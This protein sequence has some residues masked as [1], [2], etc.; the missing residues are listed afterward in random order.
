MKRRKIIVIAIFLIGLILVS[1]FGLWISNIS[2]F[3]G[4]EELLIK[5]ECDY[6][7][8][9]KVGMYEVNGNAVTNN[10]IHIYVSDCKETQINN[11]EKIFTV[12]SSNI[13]RTDLDFKWKNFD[14]IIINFNKSL[15]IFAQKN[16]T[17]SV[18]PKII[19][20]YIED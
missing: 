18:N 7:G 9:R 20:E 12:S 4:S 8:L 16:E 1:G 11:F 15:Q 5:Q 10:S 17:E 2:L 6:E 14:T 13:Q 19:I 3:E